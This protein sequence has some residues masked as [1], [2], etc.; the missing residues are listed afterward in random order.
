MHAEGGGDKKCLLFIKEYAYLNS[1][2]EQKQNTEK[3]FSCFQND[4]PENVLE[5]FVYSGKF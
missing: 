2:K 1:R 4:F 5:I 3:T